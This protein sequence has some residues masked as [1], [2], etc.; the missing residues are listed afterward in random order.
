MADPAKG[1]TF[2]RRTLLAGAAILIAAPSIVL[3]A[4]DAEDSEVK[5]VQGLAKA[6][7]L[8]EFRVSRSEQYLVIG[9]AQDGFRDE[10]LRLLS[11]LAKDYHAH[12]TSRGFDVH[13]PT[14]RMTLIVL[15]DRS[16][17]GSYLGTAPDGLVGG[18]YDPDSNDLAFFDNR[19]AG[20]GPAAEK[21]NTLVLFHE[22]THQLTFSTGLLKHGTDIP[23]AI[24]EGLANYAELRSPTGKPTK[25]GDVN[26]RR[27]LGL[28]PQGPRTPVTLTPVE[29]L[30]S[31]DERLR[32]DNTKQLA[33]SEA[34]LLV[35]YLMKTPKMQPKFKA[36][37]KAIQTQTDPNVRV[38]IWR[39][40]FGPAGQLDRELTAHLA[41]LLK[42]M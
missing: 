1:R 31:D 18:V 42:K 40:H 21:D 8:G 26:K 29:T 28:C 39:E 7:G 20:A 13:K 19:G 35:H 25:I 24:A 17:F 33:Y 38:K 32:D 23:L 6:T 5:R 30:I 4:D 12:F 16:A 41:S 14:G 27:L 15:A 10:A 37:L 3:S 22:A 2:H 36:Y 11:G 34:W 9:N